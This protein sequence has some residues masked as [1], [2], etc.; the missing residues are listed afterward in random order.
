MGANAMNPSGQ[1]HR[2]QH[3]GGRDAGA[4]FAC[5]FSGVAGRCDTV[6]VIDR[7]GHALRQASKLS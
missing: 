2:Q 3:E 1:H 6:G 7:F 5:K 4:Y